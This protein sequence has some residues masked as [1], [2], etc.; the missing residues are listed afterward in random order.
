MIHPDTILRHVNDEI[1]SG[2]FA[3]RLIPRGT[4]VWAHDLLD[5]RVEAAE[6]ERLPPG[7]R[8][9]LERY[10]YVELDGSLVLCWDLGRYINH[11]CDPTTVAIGTVMEVAARDIHPGEE[12]TSEYGPDNYALPFECGCGSPRCRRAGVGLDRAA[13]WRRWD[14]EAAAA[15]ASAGGVDQPVLRAIGVEGPAGWIVEAT[16]GGRSVSL[17]TWSAGASREDWI[18]GPRPGVSR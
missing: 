7:L 14:E 18:H 3:T 15:L 6:L 1:G 2:V 13:L 4:V 11:A 12:I 16:L 5:R 8:D 10:A 9:A 17:P